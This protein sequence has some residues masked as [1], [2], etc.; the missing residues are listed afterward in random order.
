MLYCTLKGTK[1]T[2]V[3]VIWQRARQEALKP[4]ERVKCPSVTSEKTYDHMIYILATRYKE[5]MN[6][7][8]WRNLAGNILMRGHNPVIQRNGLK[9]A[10]RHAQWFM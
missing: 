1:T 9:K 5:R 8:S 2:K 7:Q 6:K 4:R 3:K 10:T